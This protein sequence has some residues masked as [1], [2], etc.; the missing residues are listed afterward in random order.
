LEELREQENPVLLQ[1][2]QNYLSREGGD[3]QQYRADISAGY[4]K[5]ISDTCAKFGIGL[6]EARSW[7]TAVDRTVE[8]LQ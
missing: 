1:I 6:I 3:L 7:D 8:H 2:A 4:G 5:W